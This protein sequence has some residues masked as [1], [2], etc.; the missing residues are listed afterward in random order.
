MGAERDEDAELALA[1]LRDKIDSLKRQHDAERPDAGVDMQSDEGKLMEQGDA[2][3]CGQLEE[4]ELD[5]EM[6]MDEHVDGGDGA[7]DVAGA[8]AQG[9]G[10][11][12][13]KH[14][15]EHIGEQKEMVDNTSTLP[16][17]EP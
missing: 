14:P 9:L 17:R 13:A 15:P 16:F 5:E 2:Q 8:N 3:L 10:A 4:D 11:E 7:A 6:D 12:K 1:E